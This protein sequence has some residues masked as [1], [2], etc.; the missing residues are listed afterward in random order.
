MKGCEKMYESYS[1]QALPDRK[2][3]EIL[4]AALYVFNSNYDFLI[5][6][7]LHIKDKLQLQDDIDWWDLMNLEAGKLKRKLQQDSFFE[8]YKEIF[9][10]HPSLM[11]QFNHLKNRRN[12]IV[13]SFTATSDHDSH[14]QVLCSLDPKTKEQKEITEADLLEFIK[15]NEA[16]ALQLDKFRNEILNKV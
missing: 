1:R 2:Y 10:H 6:N 15:E 16:F 5:E 8:P 11:H 13:H 9:D 3:R 12:R 14:K 7:I 4:G